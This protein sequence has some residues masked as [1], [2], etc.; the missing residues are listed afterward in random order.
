[1]KKGSISGKRAL[2]EQ[3]FHEQD[4]MLLQE[5]KEENKGEE[6]KGEE[7][8]GVGSLLGPTARKRL[9]TPFFLPAAE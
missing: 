4:R 2:E 7:N 3:F 5:N 6:N 1:M 9:P 8:K